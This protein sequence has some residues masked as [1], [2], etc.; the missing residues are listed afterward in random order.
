MGIKEGGRELRHLA[1]AKYRV[2]TGEQ[3][4]IGADGVR[5]QFAAPE[6][7]ASLQEVS[8]TEENMLSEWCKATESGDVAWDVGAELGV[9]SVLAALNGA[10]VHSF[11]PRGNIA[12]KTREHLRLNDVGGEVHQLALGDYD[13]TPSDWLQKNCPG[14]DLST[15]D[16]VADSFGPPDVLKLD[17]E[18][19]ELDFL[20]GFEQTMKKDPPHTMLIEL[21]PT[22]G[23]SQ[24]GIGL[25]EEEISEVHRR[26]HGAGYNSEELDMRDGQSFIKVTQ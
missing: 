19:G 18:G 7:H 1:V 3:I 8:E 4:T 15:A 17:I 14:A 5:G 26:L 22:E 12:A 11:E 20:R 2:L 24:A 16:A 23:H 6:V 25:T 10:K 13:D 21:H 9:Y